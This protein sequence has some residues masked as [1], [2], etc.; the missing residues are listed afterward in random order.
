MRWPSRRAPELALEG[1]N[2]E[3]KG[4]KRGENNGKIERGM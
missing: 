4:G 3:K 2:K 1:E